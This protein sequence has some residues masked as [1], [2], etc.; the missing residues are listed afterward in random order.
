MRVSKT[1]QA[2]NTNKDEAEQKKT[3]RVI[4]PFLHTC[5]PHIYS[6]MQPDDESR[7]HE[8]PAQPANGHTTTTT[9]ATTTQT[10]AERDEF[11]MALAVEQARL[12]EPVTSAYCVGAVLER[13]GTVLATGYSRELPGN[14][15]AEEVCLM[16][17]TDVA[18]ADTRALEGCVMYTTM[19]PCSRRLSGKRPCAC[20]LVEAGVRRVVV[21][22]KEPP[23]FV[24]DCTGTSLDQRVLTKQNQN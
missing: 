1:E 23:T 11:Y 15:H 7:R 18:A 21:A 22:V 16:K 20:R 13:A 24:D 3:K 17:A 19:E 6:A 10:Q 8:P 12:S 14:T 4:S 5:V 9:M 2:K